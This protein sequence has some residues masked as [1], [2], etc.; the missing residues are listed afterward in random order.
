MRVD[1]SKKL[2]NKMS[3]SK[4]RESEI[5]KQLGLKHVN[6]DNPQS[7]IQKLTSNIGAIFLIGEDRQKKQLIKE[8][9]EKDKFVQEIFEFDING[10]PDLMV[11]LDD[12][13]LFT[14]E[15]SYFIKR[16]T[17][18]FSHTNRG[19]FIAYGK[20]IKK[21]NVPLINYQEIAPTILK[22]YN[23]KKPDY[24]ERDSINLFKT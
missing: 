23:L 5:N 10:F 2:Y 22:L 7:F 15:S 17:E 4:K 18:T 14:T 16:K 11:I 21:G 19:M 20:D 8:T 24:M 12:K 1:F 3:V 9:L 6:K 13:Y